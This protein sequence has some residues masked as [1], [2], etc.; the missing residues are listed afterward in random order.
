MLHQPRCFSR[1]WFATSPWAWRLR[2]ALNTP[3]LGPA[4]RARLDLGGGRSLAGRIVALD[5][6]GVHVWRDC[7]P[8]GD[9]ILQFHCWGQ[10]RV[11]QAVATVGAPLWHL[12]HQWD[13]VGERM[14]A[15][16]PRLAWLDAGFATFGPVSPDTGN[17]GATTV[18]AYV[19][20][21]ATGS[22]AT[23][24]DNPNGTFTGDGNADPFAII[25]SGASA[26]F[27]DRI[28]RSFL[29]FDASTLP[30]GTV[31]AAQIVLEG[32]AVLSGIAGCALNI[33]ASTAAAANQIGNADYD[34]LGT[35]A[36]STSI[37]VAAWNTSGSNTFAF[38]AAGL[39]TISPAILK[40]GAREANFD[41]P[42]I[43]PVHPG[44][45]Q[46]TRFEG[47]YAAGTVPP[48]LTITYT[49]PGGYG[50]GPPVLRL[51]GYPPLHLT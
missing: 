22:W 50:A 20:R 36:F 24:H 32:T 1:D 3:G 10:P 4:L 23:I 34:Q 48:V 9:P 15:W 41:A 6:H 14:A 33:Y 13:C 46:A 2:T 45:A 37:T 17:P 12:L 42:D 39:A 25:Q 47:D 49:V 43:E 44:S 28:L 31:T 26:G 5:T 30:A 11:A 38:N 51:G 7:T 40:Y 27:W 19:Q 29:H 16:H 8:Q 21:A 18:D 35:T